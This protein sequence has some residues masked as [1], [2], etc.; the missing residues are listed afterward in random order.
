MD[1]VKLPG[2]GTRPK[3]LWCSSDGSLASESA[4]P[5]DHLSCLNI[6]DS[7]SDHGASTPSIEVSF[8]V[9]ER[10]ENKPLLLGAFPL[11]SNGH[12]DRPIGCRLIS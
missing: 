11:V 6:A 4:S 8:G 7:A 3:Q 9:V 10:A 1:P 5:P 2:Q 12:R